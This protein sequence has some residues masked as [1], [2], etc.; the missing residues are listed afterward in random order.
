ML[1][2]AHIHSYSW[3][4][5][6]Q[7]DSIYSPKRRF[8]GLTTPCNGAKIFI[9]ASTAGT[10]SGTDT[11]RTQLESDVP[12]ISKGLR[13]VIH[14]NRSGARRLMCRNNM[15]RRR[16]T[17]YIKMP[18][19]LTRNQSVSQSITTINRNRT[20]TCKHQNSCSNNPPHS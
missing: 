6:V 20:T 3:H 12:A 10:T 17:K 19:S 15:L 14:R 2:A 18:R 4:I 16:E 9:S 1:L 13:D 8:D 5:W 7:L 11:S